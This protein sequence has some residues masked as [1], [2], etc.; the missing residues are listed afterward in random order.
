[1]TADIRALLEAHL[2]LIAAHEALVQRLSDT[3]SAPAPRKKS[4]DDPAP[5]P[6]GTTKTMLRACKGKAVTHWLLAEI[7]RRPGITREEL[8][9]ARGIAYAKGAGKPANAQQSAVAVAN[10]LSHAR[11]HAA[12]YGFRLEG[13]DAA[14]YTLVAASEP[15]APEA[16][17]PQKEETAVNPLRPPYDFSFR[18]QSSEL[19][20]WGRLDFRDPPPDRPAEPVSENGE[21]GLYSALF[22]R[23]LWNFY[24]NHLADLLAA[25]VQGLSLREMADYFD[26]RRE[27][28]S[29]DLCWDREALAEFVYYLGKAPTLQQAEKMVATSRLPVV[30]KPGEK[31]D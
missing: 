31:E 27:W 23:C 1:M 17:A 14:G 16:E 12:A 10:A 21:G 3:D 2:K 15:S 11:D 6:D 9:K 28:P 22:D 30:V 24:L 25:G 19:L 13:D 18:W 4:P 7:I 8:N 29:A 5:E 20:D 26:A